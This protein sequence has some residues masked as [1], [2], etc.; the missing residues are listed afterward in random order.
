[1][2]SLITPEFAVPPDVELFAIGDVH[3]YAVL[4][5]T[6]LERIENAPRIPGK[7]RI[8]VFTGDLISRGPASIAAIDLARTCGKRVQADAVIGLWGNHEQ[9][10]RL[11]MLHSDDQRCRSARALWMEHGGTNVLAELEL[12]SAE[13]LRAALGAERLAWLNGF[14][15]YHCEGS[16]LLVHGGL[17]PQIRPEPFLEA[18]IDID[19]G[20]LDY[21]QHWAWIRYTFLR[22]V[23]QDNGKRGH[24]GFLVVH[25]HTQGHLDVVTDAAGQLSRDRLNLDGGSY[26][27]GCV[28]MVHILSSQLTLHEARAGQDFSATPPVDW[29]GEAVAR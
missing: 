28:R 29:M 14:K 5:E 4:L 9:L 8:V 7:R 12:D 13:G 23:P 1:M 24:H 18:P 17:N 15:H 16:V 22:H 21:D 25:G 2:S 20:T 11:S 3:G 10:L 19:I 6:L 27:T 26:T